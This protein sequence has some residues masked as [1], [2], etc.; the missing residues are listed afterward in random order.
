[1]KAINLNLTTLEIIR[2]CKQCLLGRLTAYDIGVLGSAEFALGIKLSDEIDIWYTAHAISDNGLYLGA[3]LWDAKE[4]VI[5]FPSVII[6]A[7][8][9]RELTDAG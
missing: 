7:D 5:Y 2:T 9:Y 4:K 6:D 1:M 3:P 8:A